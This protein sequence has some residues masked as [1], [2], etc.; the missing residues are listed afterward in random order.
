MIYWNAVCITFWYL[1]YQSHA[2]FV[3]L[4]IIA[5]VHKMLIMYTKRSKI[6]CSTKFFLNRYNILSRNLDTSY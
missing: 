6:S 5:G 3:I 1:F 2:K 4:I